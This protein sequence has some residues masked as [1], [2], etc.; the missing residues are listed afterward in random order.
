M[1]P[2]SA[3]VSTTVPCP[4]CTTAVGAG[5]AWTCMSCQTSH[6]L[7]CWEA[8]HGCAVALCSDGPA[9]ADPMLRPAVPARERLV[10]DLDPPAAASPPE[11][12]Y[13]PR[14]PGG[15]RVARVIGAV[16]IAELLMLAALLLCEQ[17]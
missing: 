9:A 12:N 14:H 3:P 4:Y 1:M 16:V 2:V 11:P 6:H 15:R 13:P 8:N 5:A 10:V 7:D 17:L